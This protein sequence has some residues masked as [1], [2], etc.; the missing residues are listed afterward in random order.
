MRLPRAPACGRFDQLNVVVVRGVTGRDASTI[1]PATHFAHE[2][3]LA[4]SA[5]GTLEEES[6]KSGASS[7]Q[8]ARPENPLQH[9]LKV[10]N[11]AAGWA[12]GVSMATGWRRRRLTRPNARTTGCALWYIV[13]DVQGPRWNA[14]NARRT[15]LYRPRGGCGCGSLSS[16]GREWAEAAAAIQ[17]PA[18]SSRPG[19]ALARDGLTTR[20]VRGT[21]QFFLSTMVFVLSHVSCIGSQA[22]A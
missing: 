8:R 18:W 21:V 15:S 14:R 5:K 10:E 13:V 2:G 7:P 11:S 3:S 1:S 6:E 22:A 9:V 17:A 12:Q 16:F 19:S 4:P 20:S